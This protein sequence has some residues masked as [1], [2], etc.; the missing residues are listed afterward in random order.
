[1]KGLRLGLIVNPLA[2]IGGAVGLKGS[3]GESIV[4]EA[5]RRGAQPRAETRVDIVLQALEPYR[6]YLQWSVWGGEM[7]ERVLTKHHYTPKV[8]GSPQGQYTRADDTINAAKAMQADGV[9]LIVFAGGDGTARDLVAAV[10][11]DFPVLGIPAGVK[12]HSG[13]YAVHGQAAADILIKIL[14]GELVDVGKAEVRDI[15]E[16]AFRNGQVKAK[17]FGELLVPLADNFLQHVKCGG[18]PVEALAL[19]EIAHYVIDQMEQDYLYIVGPGSTTQAISQALDLPSTL[20]GVDIIWQQNI[21]Q[22][23]ATEAQ[24]LAQLDQRPAKI[25]ITLIGGQGHILGRG[26][27][28]ISPL[29]IKKVGKENIILVATRKKLQELSGR[30]LLVDTW[31]SEVNQALR[32]YL[33]VITGYEQSVL[34]PVQS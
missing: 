12:I 18:Q 32:G 25:I 17:H 22:L 28:Q 11:S 29:V 33:P 30:P 10:G 27:H 13:V 24:I 20:L 7:G 15:D 34:Y 14:R 4:A 23:D 8:L 2:G 21:V 5:L 6:Y 19:S 3:D 1:M 31:D 16:Q 26:N 9:D